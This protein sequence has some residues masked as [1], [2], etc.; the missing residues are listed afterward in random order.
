[1]LKVQKSSSFRHAAVN[2]GLN[3]L[4]SEDD[5]KKSNLSQAD[6]QPALGAIRDL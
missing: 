6:R 5:S 3:A 1:M 2:R 4:F